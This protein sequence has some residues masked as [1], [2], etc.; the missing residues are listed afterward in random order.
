MADRPIPETYSA[1]FA[2]RKDAERARRGDK[3][4]TE[5]AD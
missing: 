2:T 5:D 1:F 4:D 3:H